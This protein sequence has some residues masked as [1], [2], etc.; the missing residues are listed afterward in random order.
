MLIYGTINKLKTLKF[1]PENHKYLILKIK[2]W[3]FH[4]KDEATKS[5][6]SNILTDLEEAERFADISFADLKCEECQSL[7]PKVY[8]YV[9]NEPEPGVTYKYYC[10]PC[11]Q[12]SLQGSLKGP[13]A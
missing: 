7:S 11:W 2:S 5:I 8:T 6:L 3:W 12:E 13:D 1:V 10:D 9:N 4:H